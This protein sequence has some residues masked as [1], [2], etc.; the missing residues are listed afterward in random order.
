MPCART[1]S[2]TNPHMKGTNSMKK[3]MLFSLSI[4]SLL[5]LATLMPGCGSDD[6]GRWGDD[7]DH[8]EMSI[9]D[10]GDGR[11]S[12]DMSVSV[13]STDQGGHN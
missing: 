1:L 4:L 9:G 13:R 8:H 3:I 5:A 7:H 12:T 6:H 11:D 10:K 2:I